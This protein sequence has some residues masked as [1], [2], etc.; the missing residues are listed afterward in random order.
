[1]TLYQIVL[2][3][4]GGALIGLAATLMLLFNGRVTGVSGI[5]GGFVSARGDRGWQG[6]FLLGLLF[7]G[8]LLTQ[9]LPES[10]INSTG[11]TLTTTAL[12]GLFVGYGTS[13]GGGCTS[14]HGVCGV[15]RL[16]LRSIIATATF[17]GAGVITVA[18]IRISGAGL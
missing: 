6:A 16:S 8:A 1:M 12:A 10:L 4:L 2:P 17:I 15:S 18:I 13:L 9:I 11:R 3:L 14:G 5:L 7:G